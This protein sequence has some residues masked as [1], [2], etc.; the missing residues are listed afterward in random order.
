MEQEL[1]YILT[2]IGAIVIGGVLIHGMWTVRKNGSKNTKR[3]KFQESSFEP[4]FERED[5]LG[6][7]GPIY[8]D[9]GIGKV[10][11][12]NETL[13]PIEDDFEDDTIIE[14]SV[15]NENTNE[16]EDVD[17][18]DDSEL[19]TKNTQLT[20]STD[21]KEPTNGEQVDNPEQS[22]TGFEALYTPDESE[23]ESQLLASE[24]S[25]PVTKESDNE[26]HLKIV[27]AHVDAPVYSNVVTQPKP[28]YTK[29]VN[30]RAEAS[31][32]KPDDFGQ[33]PGFLLKKKD[34]ENA[35]SIATSA[36]TPIDSASSSQQNAIE[37]N[38]QDALRSKNSLPKEEIKPEPDFSLNIQDGPLVPNNNRTNGSRPIAAKQGVEK[39][40]SFA[41]QAKR[42]VRRNKKTVAEKIR[43][44]PTTKTKNA[45]DQMRIDF[46]ADNMS[47]KDDLNASINKDETPDSQTERSKS[48]SS[49]AQ[50][51]QTDVLVL[52]V[53]A[54][55][56]KPISGAALLPMLLTLGFKF[57]EHDIFH[58][59]VNTNGKGPVLFSL[60]NM[61]KPGVFDVDNMENFDTFGVS[62]FMML[63]IDGDAQQVFNM[64]HNAARKI[65]SEFGCRILDGNKVGL[66]KQSLQQYVERIR[67]FERKRINR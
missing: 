61:F 8:D 51:Q 54:E 50:E 56:D 64:M 40:L 42:F 21:E 58:R 55:N 39:E 22:K 65:S 52:N 25:A 37:D 36:D 66:S 57:G 23:D 48:P 3:A 15:L 18:A 53:R 47:R 63:P 5:D 67:E 31:R 12:V 9:V 44:E 24:E 4:G 38:Q 41:E 59:H 32:E 49:P 26:T 29:A 45:E 30:A 20:D 33:P 34:D 11:I 43:K 14:E 17:I 16:I 7:D 60:T 28:E 27:D 13:S 10:R 62:L 35:S 46:D 6:G 2:I 1:R 19:V